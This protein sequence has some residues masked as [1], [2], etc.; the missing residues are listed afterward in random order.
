MEGLKKN[1]K[2]IFQKTIVMTASNCYLYFI[3]QILI[4]NTHLLQ[5]HCGF[6][7][8]K[9]LQEIFAQN[10]GLMSLDFVLG[11]PILKLP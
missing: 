4:L 6:P 2:S 8:S 10:H 7:C 5:S 3:F 1:S 9:I 11:I